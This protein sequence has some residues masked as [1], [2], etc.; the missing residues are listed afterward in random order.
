MEEIKLILDNEL[1]DEYAEYY[2]DHH[3]R[4]TTRAIIKPRHPSMNEWM[5]MKRQ[6][7]NATKQKWKEFAVW[8]IEKLGYTNL[9][10]DSFEIIITV[11]FDSRRRVDPDNQVPKFLLDGF[12]TSGFIVD[13]SSHHLHSL[14]LRCDYDN[15]W[16]RTEVLVK[17]LDETEE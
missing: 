5:I 2:F 13:D 12:S 14:T 17:V 16:P 4:A 6:Q 8:W 15:E 9:K 1:L 10:L 7:M 3:P 11:F